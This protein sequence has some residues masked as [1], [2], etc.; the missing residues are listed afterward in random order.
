MKCGIPEVPCSQNPTQTQCKYYGHYI[1]QTR[2]VFLKK[3]H[4]A[5]HHCYIYWGE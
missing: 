1:G 4:L 3:Q 5:H 2:P